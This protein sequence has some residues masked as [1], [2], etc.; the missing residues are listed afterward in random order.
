MYVADVLVI[1]WVIPG[2]TPKYMA[3]YAE[4]LTLALAVTSQGGDPEFPQT[5]TGAEVRRGETSTASFYT[6]RGSIPEVTQ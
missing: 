4:R 3:G 2:D 5:T 1:I 6:Q